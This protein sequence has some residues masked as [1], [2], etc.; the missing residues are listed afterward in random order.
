VRWGTE[1]KNRSLEQ[2]TRAGTEELLTRVAAAA[3]AEDEWVAQL[4]AVAYELRDFL[5]E[6]EDRARAMVLEAPHGNDATRRAREQGIEALTTL[7]DRGRQELGDGASV[8][9]AA[10]AITAGVVLSRI[11]LALEAGIDAL[12][13]ELVRELMF[14]AVLPYRGLDAALTELRHDRPS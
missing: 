4:R 11:H 14:S 3:A 12:D 6:D 9:R 1:E 2:M 13:E 5:V 7:V 8:P 10:A